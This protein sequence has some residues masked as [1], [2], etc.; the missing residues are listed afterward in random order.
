MAAQLAPGPL[1]RQARLTHSA[2]AHQCHRGRS[3]TRL[4]GNGAQ[5]GFDLVQKGLAALEQT[6][7]AGVGQGLWTLAQACIHQQVE[8]K[9]AQHLRRQV[10]MP[11]EDHLWIASNRS[12]PV[13][14]GLLQRL[15][16]ACI[17]SRP[18]PERLFRL[19]SF[20]GNQN[21]PYGVAMAREGEDAVA[22]GR[23]PQQDLVVTAAGGEATSN[24]RP[25]KNIRMLKRSLL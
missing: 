18:Q 12:E 5:P 10:L 3:N 9:G 20:V 14:M 19:R 1:N 22:C 11:R 16:I 13:Q 17:A 8:H 21:R 4:L 23:I 15:L 6:A 25:S 7:E 2:L 24:Q